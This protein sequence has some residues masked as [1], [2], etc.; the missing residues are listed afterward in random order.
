MREFNGPHDRY[1]YIS[2]LV[3]RELDEACPEKSGQVMLEF[4]GVIELL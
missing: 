2:G 3:I 4:L 1:K